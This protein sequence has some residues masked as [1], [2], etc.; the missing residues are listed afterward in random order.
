MT[1][2]SYITCILA[3]SCYLCSAILFAVVLSMVEQ[4]AKPLARPVKV[5][6]FSIRYGYRINLYFVSKR[7]ILW[8]FM[9]FRFESR[10]I[11]ASFQVLCWVFL[12]SQFKV[13]ELVQYLEF[14]SVLDAWFLVVMLG[15]ELSE[16]MVCCA[17]ASSI[18]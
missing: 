6:L 17:S 5:S 15:T 11:L 3:Q 16:Q 7:K 10:K 2:S 14:F 4:A 8:K 12:D 13:T 18:F 1:H 9:E